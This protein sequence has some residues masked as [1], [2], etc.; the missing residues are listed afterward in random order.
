MLLTCYCDDSAS[1]NLALVGGLVMDKGQYE[2]LA[3]RWAKL[4]HDY[5]LPSIHM[6]E[7]VRSSGAHIGMHR[8]MKL[9]LFT[10]ITRTI[11]NN[12]LYS[13]SFGISK[14]DF[15]VIVP[16]RAAKELMRPYVMVFYAAIMVNNAISLKKGIHSKIGYMIDGGTFEDQ[17][18][19]AHGLALKWERFNSPEKHTRTG[20]IAFGS[21][22]DVIALQAADVIAWTAQRSDAGGLDAEFKPLS[23]LFEPRIQP[24]GTPANPHFHAILPRIAMEKFARDVKRGLKKTGKLPELE[25]LVPDLPHWL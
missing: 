16:P 7:F 22:D 15:D 23:K 2:K 9:S 8:E 1:N 4:L 13:I 3:Q 24:S 6:N 11:R 12:R 25:T 19:A 10:D 5:R 21:D 14:R 18:L 20:A 17:L